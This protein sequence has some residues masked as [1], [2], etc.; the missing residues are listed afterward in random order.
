MS[1]VAFTMHTGYVSKSSQ[2]QPRRM[3]REGG[4]GLK[5]EM[6]KSQRIHRGEVGSASG[7]LGLSVWIQPYVNSNNQ[8]YLLI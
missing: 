3:E 7:Q 6:P 5:K 8:S 1:N 4:C 2:R